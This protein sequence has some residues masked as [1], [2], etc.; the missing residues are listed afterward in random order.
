MIRDSIGASG[1]PRGASSHSAASA[2]RALAATRAAS[3]ARSAGSPPGVVVSNT[4][5]AS[6]SRS[7][8]FGERPSSEARKPAWSLTARAVAE[9]PPVASS[10]R[11]VRS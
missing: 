10:A 5:A 9:W 8:R 3:R 1:A 2:S 11:I 6:R 7:D 4:N